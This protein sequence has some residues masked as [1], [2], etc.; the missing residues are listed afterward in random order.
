MKNL[1][2]LL[3][4]ISVC[5]CKKPEPKLAAD[6]VYINGA[7]YTMDESSPNVEAVAIK[8]DTFL[9]VGDKIG[10]ENLIGE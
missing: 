2:V 1:H 10:L 8:A 4:L 6:S 3:L 9:Y 7:I 5:A